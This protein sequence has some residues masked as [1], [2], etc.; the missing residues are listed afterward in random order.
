MCLVG[1]ALPEAR[2][3]RTL[4]GA[5]AFTTV[6]TEFQIIGNHFCYWFCHEGAQNTHDQM[7]FR[8]LATVI[9]ICPG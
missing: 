5:A 6:W 1:S 2:R 9:L 8:G 3:I 7:T 4:S